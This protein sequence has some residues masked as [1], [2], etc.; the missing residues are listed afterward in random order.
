MAP[1]NYRHLI[2]INEK[3]RLLTIYRVKGSEY[4][5]YTSVKMPDTKYMDNPKAVDDFCRILGENIL[6]DTPIGR[7]V[8]GTEEMIL[9]LHDVG[10]VI[11]TRELFNS[12]GEAVIVIIGKPENFPDGDNCYCPYQITGIKR[13]KVRYAVGIDAVQALELALKMIGA[14]LYTS[15]E[16]HA[17]N[18]SWE[19]GEK[20]DLGFPKPDL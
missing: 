5:V 8:L 17:G 9:N 11:A 2:E 18:L 3:E 15:D 10:T 16:A 4:E 1:D 19:A 12:D 13:N 14:D 7:K 20:G 6:L